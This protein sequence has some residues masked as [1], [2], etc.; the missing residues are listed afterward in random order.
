MPRI[1]DCFPYDGEEIL[2][3]RLRLLW[4]VVDWFVI[5]EAELTHS[6]PPKALR[7]DARRHAWA[8]PKI[9][10]LRMT[11]ADFAQCAGNW[12]RE[13]MQRI[14]LKR[15][16]GD[17][18]PNDVVM[19]SDVD[20]IPNPA[21]VAGAANHPGRGIRVFDQLLFYFYGDYL[22]TSAPIWKGTRAVAAATL[23]RASLQE[24]RTRDKETGLPLVQVRD[25]GW[26][27]SY[28]GGIDRIVEKIERTVHT[29]VNVPRFKDRAQIFERILG[30]EDIFFRGARYGRTTGYDL[31]HAAVR[32]W[33]ESRAGFLSP[34]EVPYAGDAAAIAWRHRGAFR[35]LR[36][37]R[38]GVDR[39][40]KRD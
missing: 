16:L 10:Y 1:F 5:G 3:L 23:A 22:C 35:F 6:G 33:F 18:A 19:V 7:F 24:V 12:Q 39:L 40:L 38:R 8:M 14:E 25:G 13:N 26:H 28:L 11:A 17:A 31:G 29:E 4:D 37:L 20:E 9:R 36:K 34:P 32:Q 21:R 15:G 27:F 2:D 30:G